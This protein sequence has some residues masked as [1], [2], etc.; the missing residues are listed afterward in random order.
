MKISLRF[1]SLFMLLF[2]VNIIVVLLIRAI[3]QLVR[4]PIKKKTQTAH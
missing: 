4:Y 3:T 2:H 1:D